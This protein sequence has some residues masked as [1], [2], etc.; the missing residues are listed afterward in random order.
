MWSG[1]G[2]GG[3]ARFRGATSPLRPISN[4]TPKLGLGVNHAG[5]HRLAGSILDIKQRIELERS[6][7]ST[8]LRLFGSNRRRFLFF[9]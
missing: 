1:W 2:G 5:F 6:P 9:A 4:L 8:K 3:E 7:N